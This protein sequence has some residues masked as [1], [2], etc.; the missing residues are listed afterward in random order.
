MFKIASAY[1]APPNPLV[2]RGFLPSQS[3]LRA[4]GACNFPDSHVYMRKT[5]KLSPS[6][7]PPPRHLQ[8][9]NF[10][11]SNMS[12]YLKS[13][14]ICPECWGTPVS[15]GLRPCSLPIIGDAECQYVSNF[16]SALNAEGSF[17]KSVG[18]GMCD[19]LRGTE[20]E[21]VEHCYWSSPTDDLFAELCWI[22][23]T[24]AKVKIGR[25]KVFQKYWNAWYGKRD[26]KTDRE[27]DPSRP[28]ERSINLTG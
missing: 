4:F 14:K 26:S 5:L 13:L 11:T 25:K 2:G 21:F 18:C 27:R 10:F 19:E 22:T 7:S 15:L 17:S 3:Q 9:L 28:V 20:K 8:H 24:I 1:D 16:K 12:H 6:Q 23:Y